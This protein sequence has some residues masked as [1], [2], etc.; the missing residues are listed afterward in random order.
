MRLRAFFFCGIV[1]GWLGA[2][3]LFGSEPLVYA[4]PNAPFNFRDKGEVKGLGIDLLNA[5]LSSLRPKITQD[6]IRLDVW[7]E[8]YATALSHPTSFLISTT[9]LKER[10]PLFQWVGP[11]ATVRLG[12]IS[13]KGTALPSGNLSQIVRKLKIATIKETAA[14][15]MLF[16][17][18][19][20]DTNVSI[21]RLSTPLQGYKMLEYGRIDALVYTDIPFIYYLVNEEQDPNAYRMMYLLEESFYYIA[22]G[23]DIPKVQIAAMQAQLNRLKEPD[24]KGSSM[25][26]LI[27]KTYLKGAVLKGP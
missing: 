23:K 20:S 27:M 22:A 7:R 8:V 13:K 24:G 14:E 18:L 1:M 10:E 19:G 12:F 5:T 21:M 4:D 15:R 6:E 17:M 26:D 25:Y 3:A 16:Q 9:R 11:L 2:V